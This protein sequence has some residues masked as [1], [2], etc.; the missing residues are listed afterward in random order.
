MDESGEEE[1]IQVDR[2]GKGKWQ[3][4]AEKLWKKSQAKDEDRSE[5]KVDKFVH[6][7][8]NAGERH[9]HER[10]AEEAEAE[11]ST[12]RTDRDGRPSKPQFLF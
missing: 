12:D 5:P 6:K 1:E 7:V 3:R 4:R 2:R 8:D 11:K 9:P 10:E